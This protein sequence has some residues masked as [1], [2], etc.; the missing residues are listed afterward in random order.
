MRLAPL[1]GTATLA[2]VLVASVVG[3]S[4]SVTLWQE[5]EGALLDRM[6]VWRGQVPTADAFVLVEVDDATLAEFPDVSERRTGTADLLDA[7]AAAGAS[8]I[9]LDLLYL[10]EERLLPEPLTN[11]VAAWLERDAEPSEARRLL[12]EVRELTRGDERFA[13]ALKEHEVLLGFHL[14]TRG[15]DLTDTR[16]PRATYGQVVP[17]PFA[18]SGKSRGLVSLP[19]FTAAA[20]RMGFLT[21]NETGGGV[22]AVPLVRR[23]GGRHFIP[24]GLQMAAH[25]EG[26]SRG[27]M[28][29]RGDDGTVRLGDTTLEGDDG[30]LWLNWREPSSNRRVS[31]SEVLNGNVDL[32]G[33]M[34]LVAYTA[35]GQ[36]AHA[37]PWGPEPAALVHATLMDNVLVGDPL[38]RAPVWADALL[39]GLSGGLVVLAFLPVVPR[40][41]R[42]VAAAAG[43][44]VAAVVPVVSFLWAT[45]WLGMIG[46]LLAAAATSLVCFVTAWAQEGAAAR[47]LR[48]AFAHYVSDD[49]LEAMV[50]DPSL[51]QLRG[52]RRELSV[53]FSDIRDFT[54]YAE[55]IEPLVLI[56]FLNH[57]LTPMTRA[58]MA[59]RGYVDKFIGDAV[60]A[61][62][63]A[64]V[65][66]E[67]HAANAARTA[68]DMFQGLDDVR[69]EARRLG[70]DLQIGVGINSGT[71]AVGN[72]GSDQRVEYTVLGDAVNLA[73]RLEGLT[74]SYGVFCL[75]GPATAAALSDVFV[76]RWI[77][78]V[79]VKGKDLPVDIH[80]LCADDRRA[81][82]TYR[83]LAQWEAAREALM[84]GD[85]VGA[86]L[87]FTAFASHNPD[88]PVVRIHLQR[89]AELDE[90]PPDWDGV[91]THL[92]K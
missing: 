25:H 72:M 86:R 85:L 20:S 22:R 54:T 58:V 42:P 15:D 37:T 38:H 44:V 11:D 12:T 47:A 65:A 71:V 49:L 36:D 19:A 48:S 4:Q 28:V 6:F 23:I 35:F 81:I 87:A 18:P 17:G 88:D 92:R 70:V 90:L 50:A 33:R 27:K 14:G 63:G 66:D 89:L 40:R 26:L 13:A 68:V 1:L 10:D 31:A 3:R 29:Y 77:D 46:G 78:R 61:L 82:V 43:F 9:T 76:T 2:L 69:P 67:D 34:A 30:Q 45:T 56:G 55:R 32:S 74:K 7:I 83:S 51:V 39:T 79:R 5:A 80:E 75:L 64:P 8:S 21:V 62:F 59:H 52:Q 41:I 53:L 60:M 24:L 91:Y 73:S 84:N 57:Y 16:I